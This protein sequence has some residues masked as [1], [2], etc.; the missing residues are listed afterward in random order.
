MVV[1]AAKASHHNNHNETPQQQQPK[2]GAAAP[3]LKSLKNI[4]APARVSQRPSVSCLVPP[5]C[6]AHAR[7]IACVSVCLGCYIGCVCVCYTPPLR[8]FLPP[9]FLQL[10]VSREHA[11]FKAKP[12]RGRK[13][14]GERWAERGANAAML[15][16]SCNGL[17]SFGRLVVWSRTIAASS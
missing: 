11:P 4:V 15:L 3:W 13:E 8:G 14:R 17:P 6:A 16:P 1:W 5:S 12:A 7:M 2:P 9:K 10:G